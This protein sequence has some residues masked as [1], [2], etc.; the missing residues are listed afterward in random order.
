[1]FGL[2]P[3]VLILLIILGFACCMAVSIAT[4]M[5]IYRREFAAFLKGRDVESKHKVDLS[6]ETTTIPIK[7][8]ER[9]FLNLEKKLT[10]QKFMWRKR[11][12]DY[13]CFHGLIFSQRIKC[14]VTSLDNGE[15]NFRLRFSFYDRFLNP[16]MVSMV[17][18]KYKRNM[19]KMFEKLTKDL[20]SRERELGSAP[21]I[22]IID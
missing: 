13:C 19:S 4:T 16:V 20:F 21:D 5:V 8:R 11:G 14:V 9:I 6:F 7:D 3:W 22:G 10:E 17:R 1:M 2:E 15:D 18:E 12:S